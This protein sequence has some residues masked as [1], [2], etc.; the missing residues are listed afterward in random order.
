MADMNDKHIA[1][2]ISEEFSEGLERAAM[3]LSGRWI[4]LY[5][6]RMDEESRRNWATFLLDELDKLNDTMGVI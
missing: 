5:G 3:N 2:M 4:E 1:K 6:E